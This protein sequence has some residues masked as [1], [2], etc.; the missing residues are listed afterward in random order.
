MTIDDEVFVALMTER[1]RKEEPELGHL[2]A[3]IHYK[4]AFVERFGLEEGF[5]RCREQLRVPGLE[6]LS[7]K[8]VISL[9]K[10]AEC[11]PTCNLLWDGG[12]RFVH[13]VPEVIGES[14]A[15]EQSGLSR[16]AFLTC[17]EDVAIRGR[18]A[19][20][21]TPTKAIVDYENDELE[22]FADSPELDPGV[23]HAGKDGYWVMEPVEYPMAIDEAFMLSGSHTN[24]F[25]HWLTEYL[26]KLAI[27]L[28]AGL[29]QVPIIVDKGMP[30]SHTQSIE[31]LCPWAR[32]IVL[33]H[34]SSCRVRKLWC[35]SNPVYRGYY[36]TDWTSAW[37]GM[38]PDPDNFA[39][40]IRE[41]KR[42][43]EDAIRPATGHERVFLARHPK[44]KKKLANH[45]AIEA[46]AAA[47]GF[48]VVY[49][50]DLAFEE[51]LRL[52]HH[53]RHVV[54]PDGSNGLLAY[55]VSPGARVC[56]LNSPH[57]LPLVELSGILAALGAEFSIIT[58]P[59][60]SETDE[61]FWNDYTIDEAAFSNFLDRWLQTGVESG[62]G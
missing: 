4:R 7:Q 57:T 12:R 40:A 41:L 38:L 3:A 28:M 58:G 33:P 8:T 25:G 42:L 36:P 21:L 46:A 5:E 23:L 20:V 6:R 51:Q 43:A 24:D 17:L 22:C 19:I 16:S 27:A 26:P 14:D 39:R 59:M 50:E 1:L 9:K 31:L 44:R 49:P 54:A 2:I 11:A 30:R 62:Q 60:V 18:S 45:A 34:L 53:A 61:P 13:P 15:V 29:P 56:F 32:I 52:V 10:A 35:A 47:R 37:K 48:H 55:F